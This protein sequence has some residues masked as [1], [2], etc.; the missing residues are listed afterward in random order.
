MALCVCVCVCM[1]ECVHTH[2]SDS[3][4]CK[5]MSSPVRDQKIKNK[6]NTKTLWAKQAC[7]SLLPIGQGHTHTHTQ[8]QD[9]HSAWNKSVRICTQPF[10]GVRTV[11]I[12]LLAC[13]RFVDLWAGAASRCQNS[14]VC[15]PLHIKHS[16]LSIQIIERLS[17]WCAVVFLLVCIHGVV[18]DLFMSESAEQTGRAAAARTGPLILMR[19]AYW[20][21]TPLHWHV[22]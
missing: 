7:Q 5:M 22:N 17:L 15:L 20:P 4:S 10:T 16:T 3:G 12:L 8:R 1:C 6:K 19:Q 11:D 13:G 9:T 21:I 18:G 2:A 14:A